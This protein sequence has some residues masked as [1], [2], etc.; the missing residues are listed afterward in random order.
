MKNFESIKRELKARGVMFED[1]VFTDDAV[2]ARL[3]DTSIDKNY[4]PANSIK[5]LIISTKDGYKAVILRG[6]DRIDQVKLKGLVGKW[7]VVDANILAER[8]QSLPG[9]I[10]PL[11]LDIP[12][13]IDDQVLT[14]KVWS[15]GAGAV[16]RGVNVEVN[17]A[18]KHIGKHE[19]V[20]IS[21]SI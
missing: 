5:T 12:I 16:N 17:E 11:V 1:V 20:S 21:S 14:L 7:S 2:S 19:V 13:L 8:F 9:T 3:S 6:S 10:C 4:N 15:M 18:V